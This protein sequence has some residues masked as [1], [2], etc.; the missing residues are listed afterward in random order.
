MALQTA[1]YVPGP[2]VESEDIVVGTEKVLKKCE[3][4]RGSGI[5]TE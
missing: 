4:Y 5:Q 2:F 3:G 1:F